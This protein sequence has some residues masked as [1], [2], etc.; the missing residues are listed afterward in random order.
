LDVAKDDP[1][2][3]GLFAAINELLAAF[4]RHNTSNSQ[5]VFV[6]LQVGLTQDMLAGL[7]GAAA[8][9]YEILRDN[10]PLAR[11]LAHGFF[12]KL[13]GQLAVE[14]ERLE[15]EPNILNIIKVR[16][17]CRIDMCSM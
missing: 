11:M 4:V 10:P 16:G 15:P 5:E 1:E 8:V 17:A 7:P 9:L 6:A 14:D 12:E 3:R 13:L 2:W